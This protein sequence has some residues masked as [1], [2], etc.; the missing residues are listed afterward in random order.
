M[1]TTAR[2]KNVPRQAQQDSSG[3]FL[4]AALGLLLIAAAFLV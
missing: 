2:E 3:L 4:I 1:S